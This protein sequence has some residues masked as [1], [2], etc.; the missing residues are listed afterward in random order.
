M[1]EFAFLKATRFW[2]LVI[3]ALS[4]YMK[5]KGWIGEAEMTLIASIMGGFIA[6]RTVDR[7]SEQVIVAQAVSTGEVKAEDVIKIP[8]TQSDNLVAGPEKK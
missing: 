2:A 4:V 1:K 6:V 5:L 3:G 7:Y 8:L